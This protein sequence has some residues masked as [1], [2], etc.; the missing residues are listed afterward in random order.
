VF[1]GCFALHVWFFCFFLNFEYCYSLSFKLNDVF[2]FSVTEHIKVL[3]GLENGQRLGQ[4]RP[5]CVFVCVCVL[6]DVGA[7]VWN[8]YLTNEM[9]N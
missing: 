2:S 3:D 4:S 9:H 1:I 8:I 5:L 7:C 6:C